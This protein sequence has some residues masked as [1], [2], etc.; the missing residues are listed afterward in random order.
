MTAVRRNLIT[1]EPILFAPEREGR[2]NAFN[3]DDAVCPFCPGNEEMTPPE[4][5]RIGEPWRVRVFPNKYPFA[6][7]HEVIVESQRHDAEFDQIDAG[8]VVRMYV[9]RYC[10]L[11]HRI[12]VRSVMLFKNHGRTAG[13]SLPHLHSQIAALGFV[14]PRIACEER[15]FAKSISCPLCDAI[16]T[17]RV[18]ELIIDE[19]PSMVRL[20]PHGSSFANQQWIMPKRHCNDLEN[21]KEAECRELA[22]LLQHAAAGM[23]KISPSHNW[24]FLTFPAVTAAHCYV[25]LF[26]R[27]TSVAGFELATGTFIDSIDPSVTVRTMGES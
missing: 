14:P 24:M 27:T 18:A 25:D 8:E 21:L 2:P 20:A 22:V 11:V 1:G 3:E 12:G 17:H 6:E 23:R 7:H 13:A 16:N 19:T 9:E 26:P 4:V 15:A 5:A 10:A